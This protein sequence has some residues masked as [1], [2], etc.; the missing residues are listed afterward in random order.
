MISGCSM[1]KRQ[2]IPSVIKKSRPSPPQIIHFPNEA[3]LSENCS[4][5]FDGVYLL[6][7]IG[8]KHPISS[9]KEVKVQCFVMCRTEKS[10]QFICFSQMFPN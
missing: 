9:T 1:V 10:I 8:S 4:N 7:G 3:F 6:T 5:K 2:F